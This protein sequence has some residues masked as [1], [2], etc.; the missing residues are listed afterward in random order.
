MSISLKEIADMTG[1][2][3]EGDG[4]VV[5]TGLAGLKDAV[6]GDLSF[7]SNPRYASLMEGTAASAVIVAEDWSG[8]VSCPV[9]KVDN[10]DGAFS[11]VAEVLGHKAIEFEPGIHRSAVIAD[12][13]EIGENV[14][15]GGV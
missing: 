4:S 6:Q 2:V 5:V 15:I 7:L 11:V 13:A 1:G 12:N 9:I 8:E 10:P 14:Y 3:V